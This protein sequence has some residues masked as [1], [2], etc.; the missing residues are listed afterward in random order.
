METQENPNAHYLV[1][2]AWDR[3]R[4]VQDKYVAYWQSRRGVGITRDRLESFSRVWL[5]V[6]AGSGDFFIEMARRQPDTLHIAI[7]RDRMRGKALVRRGTKAALPNLSPFRGNVVPT[8]MTEIPEGTLDRIFILYPCPWPKNS[9]RK[10]RWYNHPVMAHM[11]RALRPGGRLVWASDQ[12]FY[13]DEARYASETYHGME[14]LAHGPLS[15][16]PDNGLE[17]FCAGRTKFESTFLAGGQPCFELIAAK[18][19]QI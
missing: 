3:T 11:V 2:S 9:Q 6:G 1:Q 19:S 17:H 4:R 8:F 16:H 15:P 13:V 5:E 12:K 14:I 7:E 18:K 10:N